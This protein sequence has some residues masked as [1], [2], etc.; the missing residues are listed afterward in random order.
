MDSGLDH[1]MDW[2]V[3]WTQDLWKCGLLNSLQVARGR[4]KPGACSLKI[5]RLY[6]CNDLYAGNTS[7]WSCDYGCVW[8]RI[9]CI[10]ALGLSGFNLLG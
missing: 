5:A 6:I 10:G 7:G 8:P 2:N 3:D 4:K 9:K 1:A